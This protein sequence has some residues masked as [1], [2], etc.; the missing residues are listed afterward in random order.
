MATR[1]A[2]KKTS[3]EPTHWRSHITISMPHDVEQ[4]IRAA[5]AADGRTVSNYLVQLFL[6]ERERR[7]A[8]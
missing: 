2:A 7:G 6:R 5:A 8:R 3:N 4:E 1:R